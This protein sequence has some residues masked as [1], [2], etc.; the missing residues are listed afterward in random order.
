MT[1]P[2]QSLLNPE[3]GFGLLFPMISPAQFPQMFSS[4]IKIQQLSG[5]GP[6]VVLEIPD[7]RRPVGHHQLFL[8]P[9]QAPTQCL[10]VLPLPKVQR[11]SLPTD[12]TLASNHCP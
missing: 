5:L 11:P 8:C 3:L 4:V 10:P 2:M 7:P 1:Q 9:R 6:S 12:Q